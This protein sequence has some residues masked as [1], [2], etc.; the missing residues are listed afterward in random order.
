[1]YLDENDISCR[2]PWESVEEANSAAEA[3]RAAYMAMSYSVDPMEDK[4][5]YITDV[6]DLGYMDEKPYY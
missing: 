3:E 4:M 2:E 5:I 6:K 1:M